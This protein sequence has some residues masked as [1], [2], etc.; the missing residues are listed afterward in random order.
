MTDPSGNT[1][2][3]DPETGYY[4]NPD[5]PD[6]YYDPATGQY[7]SKPSDDPPVNNTPDI[8]EGYTIGYS[9]PSEDIY[10]IVRA[11]TAGR[12]YMGYD[13]ESDSW[14]GLNLGVGID[15]EDDNYLIRTFF[16]GIGDNE[17]VYYQ[18]R[19]LRSTT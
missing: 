14:F 17:V 11:G 12:S 3:Y 13:K 8:P 15:P 2:Y 4:I 19:E 5:Y 7:L 1:V 16:T 10:V 18:I 9:E 6:L